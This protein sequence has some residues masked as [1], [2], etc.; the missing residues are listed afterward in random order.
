MK[1]NRRQMLIVDQGEGLPKDNFSDVNKACTDWAKRR[2]LWTPNWNQKPPV[3]K[4]K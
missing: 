1:I 2:N 3:A 4:Q